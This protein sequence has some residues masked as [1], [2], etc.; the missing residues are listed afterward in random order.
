M[1]PAGADPVLAVLVFLNL[2]E[3]TPIALPSS[4]WLI[5]R[6]LRKSRMRAP[7]NEST[8]SF[9]FA[10]MLLPSLK[11]QNSDVNLLGQGAGLSRRRWYASLKTMNARRAGPP[12]EKPRPG[13][14]DRG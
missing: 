6:R 4:A 8:G 3:V 5:L 9:A 2:L 10:R 11:N 14:S 7:T 12:N 1:Q 13:G